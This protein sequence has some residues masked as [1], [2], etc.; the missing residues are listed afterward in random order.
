MICRQ[1]VNI[2]T[3]SLRTAN[4]RPRGTIGWFHVALFQSN[5]TYLV[6]F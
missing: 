6:L 3:Y 4:K 5:K 2:A 1:K